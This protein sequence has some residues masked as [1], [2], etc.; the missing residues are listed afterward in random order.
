[1]RLPRG[2]AAVAVAVAAS[3]FA[4]FEI[5][6]GGESLGS[7]LVTVYNL[8]AKCQRPRTRAC[9]LGL[10]RDPYADYT[11]QNIARYVWHGDVLRAECLVSNGSPIRGENGRL[12]SRWYRVTGPPGSRSA[13]TRER[14]WL[15]A[16]RIH[17][18]SEPAVPRCAKT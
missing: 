17:P 4:T 16:V 1:M 3:G 10:A 6:R 8:Q 11:R 2:A 7:A 9:H 5:L 13:A 14:A 18:G 12:T 15:P